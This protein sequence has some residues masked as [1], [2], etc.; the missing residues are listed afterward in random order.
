[1][2]PSRGGRR[3]D[4][5]LPS[6]DT[7]LVFDAMMELVAYHEVV[8]G[9]DGQ[10]T[11]YRV[12]DCNAAFT[13]VTGIPREKAV[14]R[15]ASEVYGTA[16][17]YLE[18]Y[19]RVAASGEPARFDTY[20]P[21]MDRH[22]SISVVSPR[23]GAFV[24]VATDTTDQHRDAEALNRYR[25]LAESGLDI[26]LF[27]RRDDGRILGAN[28]AAVTA[29]GYT[30]DELRN[31]SIYD[32]RQPSDHSLV[33]SQMASA[34]ADGCRFETVHRRKDHSTFHVE[35]SANG[36]ELDGERVVVNVVRDVTERKRAEE[37]LASERE[38]LAVTL[39]SI[40]DAVI[41]TD[42]E[43]HIT[44]FNGMAERLTGWRG[45]EAV[46][47]PLHEV[48]RIINEDTRL[49][50]SNPAERVLRE[51]VVVGLA[52]HTALLSRDGTERP[53]ADSGAPIRDR[54]GHIR[55]AVLVFRDQT[56]ER[57]A[58]EALAASE[59]LY[60][61]LF[62]LVPCGVFLVGDKGKILAFNDRAAA[63]A[64]YTRAEY[65]QL[66]ISDFNADQ[67]PRAIEERTAR[68]LS[69][70][71]H[72]FEARHRTKG[73]EVRNVLI[74]AR[75]VSIGR[76][77]RVLAMVQ[78]QT[79]RQRAADA[80]RESEERFRLAFQ[81]SPDAI[82]INRL[83]DGVCLAANDGFTH[84]LGWTEAEVRGHSGDIRVWDD[85]AD[86]ARL[87]AQLQARGYVENL[88]AVF[89]AKSG[90]QVSGLMSA[91]VF[92]MRGEQLIL[93]ITRDIGDWKKAE[94][95][96]DALQGRLQQAAKM[97]AIGQLA[98][99][100]AHD[101]NNLLTVILSCPRLNRGFQ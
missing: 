59:S 21:P 26:V 66:N 74:S 96:R 77:M 60:R 53:I 48:F 8:Y 22:F 89:R 4:R 57:R 71:E 40:G 91:R 20:F 70:V 67:S 34:A 68:I 10:A 88:E 35:V 33:A 84:I 16:A 55:G 47:R 99:G 19:A 61:N 98:G 37:A 1:M 75:P 42:D 90:R 17:P 86:R 50:A 78:D 65:E 69:G 31:L 62:N 101:F 76:E 94:A 5:V 7:R 29:Y 49:P 45:S 82:C 6:T 44:V 46:G 3:R 93:S 87:L 9:T 80:L 56:E 36:R 79:E 83:D 51:G 73:G 58:K 100:V 15:L 11:D 12:L 27:L 95:E 43:A 23:R 92:Q 97:E 32:L 39:Q 14:G 72:Q 63:Q 30:R 64:G 18:V 25:L 38:R 54:S 28:A 2:K 52:N 13:V 81:T 41:A 24:T 85:P